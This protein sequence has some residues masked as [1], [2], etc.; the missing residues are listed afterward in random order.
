M[1]FTD[2]I[3]TKTEGEF[4]PIIWDMCFKIADFHKMKEKGII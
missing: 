3:K 2:D 4:H 1:T